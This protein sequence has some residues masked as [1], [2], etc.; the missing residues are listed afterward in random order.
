MI[1]SDF[2]LTVYSSVIVI[3]SMEC[4]INVVR[5]IFLLVLF[6][7][8]TLSVI[9]LGVDVDWLVNGA[10]FMAKVMSRVK[11]RLVNE[12]E[13]DEEKLLE[14]LTE[15]RQSVWLQMFVIIIIAIAV[16]FI[17]STLFGCAGACSLSYSLLSGLNYSRISS[18]TISLVQVTPSS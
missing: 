17:I 18:T 15:V 13:S 5:Y 6:L 11:E 9:V 8:L 1:V 4:C 2:H 12:E 3:I 10:G 14:E 16:V 7:S